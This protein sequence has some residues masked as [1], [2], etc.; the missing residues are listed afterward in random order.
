[1]DVH[2]PKCG[3]PW[4]IDCFHDVAEDEGSTFDAVRKDF[5]K[6]GCRAVW[7]SRCNGNEGSEM[8]VV[9]S[10]AFELM[11]DDIDGVASM[12]SDYEGGF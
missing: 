5:V 4:D 10:A 3:E 1:M 12:L 11:G 7:N 9:A 8:A 6:R 2:C